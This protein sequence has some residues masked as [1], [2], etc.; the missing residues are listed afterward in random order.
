MIDQIPLKL[1]QMNKLILQ[2]N[3]DTKLSALGYQN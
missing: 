1:I 3:N 2:S